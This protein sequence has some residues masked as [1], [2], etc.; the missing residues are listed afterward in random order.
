M[1]ETQLHIGKLWQSPVGTV[2]KFHLDLPVKFNK[3]EIDV[4][5]TFTCDVTLIKL[6]DEISVIIK[7]AHIVVN[8]KCEKCLKTYKHNLQILEAEREFL[9]EAPK[10]NID[11]NE[12]FLINRDKMTIDLHNMIR[13]EIILH[14]PLIAVC[15]NSCK[16][17]CEVCG[18]DKNK[19]ECNCKKE[20]KLGVQTPF[21]NLAKLIKDS[22]N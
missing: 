4:V 14:F 5:S 12:Y 22:T 13:Q 11:E 2:E 18:K 10:K 3:D 17:L 9:Y 1:Q 6:K 19:Q 8:L 21:K 20:E 7:N 16:G 15:S